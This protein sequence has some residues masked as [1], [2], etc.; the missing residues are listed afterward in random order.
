MNH[1]MDND[2]VVLDV[3]AGNKADLVRGN[4]PGHETL[5]PR[6]KKFRE[7][8]VDD[9]TKRYGSKLGYFFREVNFGDESD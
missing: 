2:D 4:N 3:S 1:L 7:T 6:H 5:E 8:L 9:V